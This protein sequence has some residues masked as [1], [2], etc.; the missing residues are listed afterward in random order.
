TPRWARRPWTVR[1]SAPPGRTELTPST[2]EAAGP[3]D[4]P[5]T[6]GLVEPERPVGPASAGTAR[7]APLGQLVP[8]DRSRL[9]V[10]G[11]LGGELGEVVLHLAPDPSH[12]DAE[13]A[14]SALHE[15]EHLV[16]GGALV[17]AGA[18]THQRD[19]RQVVH[20]ALTQ[21]GDRGADLLQR[22][23]GVQQ[24]LDDLQHQHVP[25]AV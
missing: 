1:W 24:P 11:A 12:G 9:L 19:L 10:P 25:E 23:P 13:H 7:G 15:V 6:A 4:R 22:H 14:L 3:G 5:P 16:G 20:P 17:D 21:V 8:G 18:V 2:L